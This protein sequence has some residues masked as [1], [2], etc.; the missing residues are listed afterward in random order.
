MNVPERLL[1]FSAFER[2]L[3]AAGHRAGSESAAL[4]SAERVLAAV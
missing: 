2:V 1:L 3:R 4:A